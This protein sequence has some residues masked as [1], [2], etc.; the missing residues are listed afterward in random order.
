MS[1]IFSI[2]KIQFPNGKVYIGQS[3][4]V[5]NRWREHLR[6]AAL[7]NETKVYRAMRKYHII[8]DNFSILESN[9][10]TQEEANAKE[11]Y[12]ISQYDS[13]HNGYNCNSGGGNTEHIKGENHPNWGKHLSA[14]TKSKIGKGGVICI[15]TGKY[16]CSSNEA[17]KDVGLKSGAHIRDVCRGERKTGGCGRKPTHYR[18]CK[19]V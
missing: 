16:Y 7:G 13:W 1:K 18:Q 14:E 12:Y 15:E 9:I 11:I 19:E 17:A 2:Y 10:L 3:Y 4:N 6:E 8:I 5:H